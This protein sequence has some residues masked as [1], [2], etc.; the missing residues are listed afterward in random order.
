MIYPISFSIPES[1]IVGSMPQK[2]RRMASI[3]PGCDYS[4]DQYKTYSA[5]YQRSL[6]G[7]TWKKAGWDCLRHYEIIA[8]GCIPW[9]I[10]FKNAPKN[11]LTTIPEWISTDSPEMQRAWS[12]ERDATELTERL[13]EHARKHMTCRAAAS[14]ILELSGN[15]N[16]ERVLWVNAEAPDYLDTLTLIGMKQLLGSNCTET[17]P[18]NWL[19]SDF[20][21]SASHLYGRGF[22]YTCNLHSEW[23]SVVGDIRDYDVIVWGSWTRSKMFWNE[24]MELL[25]HNKM[26]RLIGEDYIWQADSIDVPTFVRELQ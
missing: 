20:N 2:T 19:Y 9:F 10:D 24:A 15:R 16:A 14:R 7:M 1:L 8:N 17:T 5:E 23:R 18:H 22:T 6:F 12:S 13:L 4:F 26:I 11:T 3:V 21:A 25:D